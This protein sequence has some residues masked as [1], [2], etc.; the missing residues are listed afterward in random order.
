M[1]E[2][3]TVDNMIRVSNMSTYL[4]SRFKLKGGDTVAYRTPYVWWSRTLAG[5]RM[6]NPL[7]EPSLL[8]SEWVTDGEPP[9][10]TPFWDRRAI[11][12]WYA[13]WKGLDARKPRKLKGGGKRMEVMV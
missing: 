10:L 8:I 2:P 6:V 5:T 11:V 3:T 12:V 4:N 13:E 1:T 7:P 9:E